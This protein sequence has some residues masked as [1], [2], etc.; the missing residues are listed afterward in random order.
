VSAGTLADAPT[1][2]SSAHDFVSWGTKRAD[3]RATCTLDGA[4]ADSAAVVLDAIN[5]I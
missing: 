3:W 1:L 5:I 4:R 2:T